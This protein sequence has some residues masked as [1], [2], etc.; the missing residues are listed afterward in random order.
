[1]ADAH[2]NLIPD[3]RGDLFDIRAA[4]APGDASGFGVRIHGEELHWGAAGTI[5]F[6]DCEVAAPTGPEGRLDLRLL[7][8]RTSLELF[9]NGG[10]VSASF[11]YLPGPRDCAL[12]FYAE[13]GTVRFDELIVWELNS[14]W[15]ETK[16]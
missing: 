14:A 9:V 3:T 13:G 16:P 10:E 7:V 8:D 11:C 6:L 2:D 4:V 1:M 15:K 12:E 5:R